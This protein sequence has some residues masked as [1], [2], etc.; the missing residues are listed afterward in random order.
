MNNNIRTYNIFCYINILFT[1]YLVYM[2]L[3]ISAIGISLVTL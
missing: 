3:L 2:I 1:V